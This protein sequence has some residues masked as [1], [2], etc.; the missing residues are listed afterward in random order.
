MS[1]VIVHVG[2][3]KTGSS[4]IQSLLS[5]NRLVLADFGICYPPGK[6]EYRAARGQPTS[7]NG[8]ILLHSSFSAPKSGKVLFSSENLFSTIVS[9]NAS[10]C[11]SYGGVGLKVILYT[12]NVFDF[13]ASIWGQVIKS[14]GYFESYD[15]FLRERLPNHL[16]VIT[17]WI[18]A[19]RKYG[20]ELVVKNYH[21]YR[22]NLAESFFSII[23]PEITFHDL[24]LSYPPVRRVNRSLL[25]S[26]LLVVRLFNKFGTKGLSGRFVN[27]PRDGLPGCH[28]ISEDTYRQICRKITPYV[29]F[30][31]EFVDSRERIT[32][33]SY[34]LLSGQSASDTVSD[35]DSE[36]MDCVIDFIEKNFFSRTIADSYVDELKKI[37]TKIENDEKLLLSDSLLLLQLAAL[38]RPNGP[39]IASK[40][41]D[42]ESLLSPR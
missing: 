1:K 22:G 33:E 9:G 10:F 35:L 7:G 25:P 13:Y 29:D 27:L 11:A 19:S 34:S 15:T 42:L 26:E 38:I 18:E 4:M 8:D 3:P 6:N 14:G 16:Y 32:I 30:I 17:R 23:L 21:N 24:K 2:H 12:R 36:Q 31:N 28:P 37:S 40:I 20:F 39:L 5:V 41:K